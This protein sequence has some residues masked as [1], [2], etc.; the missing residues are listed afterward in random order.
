MAGGTGA[1]GFRA[2]LIGALAAAAAVMAA[3]SSGK[4][5][6]DPVTIVVPAREAAVRM[7]F[8]MAAMRPSYLVSYQA[9]PG[10]EAPWLHVWDAAARRWIETTLE[11]YGAGANFG[12]MPRTVFL[13]G[14]EIEFP[15]QLE[16]LA[17]WADRSV[18]LTTLDP[19]PCLNAFHEAFAFTPAEWRWLA[20]RYNLDLKDLNE[21]RRRY[22]RYGPPGQP[23][24]EANLPPRGLA[25]PPPSDRTA[26]A[27]FVRQAE[28]PQPPVQPEVEPPAQPQPP[29]PAPEPPAPKVESAPQ[30]PPEPVSAPAAALIP[31]GPP[32][33]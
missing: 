12:R 2:G 21:Q 17:G 23:P 26:V 22:G 33:K 16:D 13:L 28:E 3:P 27:P 11:A 29:E 7:A 6:P 19:M 15:A 18:R 30:P 20:R 14:T 25:T 10:T 31:V 32:V 4:G 8:D 24:P 5:A 9:R 1:V